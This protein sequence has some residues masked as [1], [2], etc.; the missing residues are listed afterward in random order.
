MNPL[1]IATLAA[2]AA[3][4]LGVWAVLGLLVPQRVDLLD[5]L[6]R[7]R[8]LAKLTSPVRVQHPDQ[9][10]SRLA[11]AQLA[12][13]TRLSKL[14]IATPDS[15]LRV[16][17][18]SRG[19][20]LLIRLGV[21]F[22]GLLVIPIYTLLFVAFGYGVA[23]AIPAVIGLVAAGVGWALVGRIVHGR[24]EERRREMR[25][26]LVSYLTL[27]ALHRAAG[28]GMASAL[29]LAA[30]SS[31]TWTFRRI[32]QRVASSLRTGGAAWDGL[33]NLATELGIEELAD[34]S[35]IADNA[36]TQGAGVYSTLLARAQ[37][38]RNELQSQ[39][40]AAAS[41]ASARMVVPKAM[42]GIV[43]LIFLLYPA[44]IRIAG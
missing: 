11:A 21:V 2:G 22:G 29:E 10:V 9:E 40:E 43:T 39:E 6:N 25:Y 42:L 27:L 15:D 17:E 38:L 35:S 3:V 18:M 12:L 14:S 16:I 32:D 8:G 20:F 4:G 23:P 1:L 33:A 36:G 24:A 28:E 7:E 19:N 5:A 41:I 13:E 37:A 31:P 44:V 30:A 26:A 34:L